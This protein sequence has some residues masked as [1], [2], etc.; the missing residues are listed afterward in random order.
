MYTRYR[1]VW[2]EG[3]AEDCIKLSWQRFV[4]WL[5]LVLLPLIC[6][7]CF[8]PARLV[9][10]AKDKSK[11]SCATR[12]ASRLATLLRHATRPVSDD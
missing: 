12:P 1:R 9:L 5:C 11:N 7:S 10:L 8:L 3:G 2:G 6:L 4:S